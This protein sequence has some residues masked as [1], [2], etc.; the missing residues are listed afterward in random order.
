[1]TSRVVFGKEAKDLTVA[2]QFVLASAVNSPIILLPGSD[3]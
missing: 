2:E 3:G 1:M